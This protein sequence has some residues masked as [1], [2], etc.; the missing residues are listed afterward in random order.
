MRVRVEVRSADGST[1]VGHRVALRVNDNLLEEVQA[2]VD[3]VTTPLFN[4]RLRYL[5]VIGCGTGLTKRLVVEPGGG[6]KDGAI[7]PVLVILA[8]G[9]GPVGR[10]R[11]RGWRGRRVQPVVGLEGEHEGPRCGVV[12]RLGRHGGGIVARGP[13]LRLLVVGVVPSLVIGAGVVEH[14]HVVGH[15]CDGETSGDGGANLQPF[16]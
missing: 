14:H 13:R 6:W 4:H 11:S 9:G 2:P 12:E 7:S 3:P 16:A 10:H 1:H 5:L 8:A 15:C